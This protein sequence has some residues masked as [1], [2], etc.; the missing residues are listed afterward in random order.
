[1]REQALGEGRV[2]EMIGTALGLGFIAPKQFL[3]CGGIFFLCIPLI[4]RNPPQGLLIF[5]CIYGP[6]WMLTGNDPTKFFE[7][8]HKPKK[9]IAEEPVLEFN[10]AGIP[11]PVKP[12]RE[13]TTYRIKGK[14]RTYHHIERKFHLLTYGQIELEGKEIGFYLLRRGTQLMFIFAWEV[15]GHDPSM[16]GQQAMEIL[17]AC[18]DALTNVPGDIDLKCYQEIVATCEAYLRMQAALLASKEHDTLSRELIKSR[19]RRGKQLCEE[20]RLVENSITVFAKY[21]V[22]LGGEYA[23]SETWLDELLAKTQ[24]LVGALKGKNFESQ[25]AWEKVIDYA[26]RYAYRKVNSQLSSPQGFGMRLRTKTVHELFGADY[27]KLHKPPVPPV[28]QY[29]VYNED[30]LQP[31]VVHDLG[32]HAIGTLFEPQGGISAKPEFDRHYAYLPVKQQYEAFVRLG[33]VRSFPKDKENVA[34]GYLRF[35][36]NILSGTTEAIYNCRVVT[37]LTP[38]RSGF[39]MLQLDRMISNSV[40]REALAAK[41]QTV[42]VVAMRRREQAIEARDLLEDKNLPY[43]CSVGVWLYRDSLDELN[44]ATNELIGRIQAAASVERVMNA[45]EDVWFQSWP[46]EWEAFLTKPHHRRQKYLGFQALPMLP[47]IKVK[48]ADKQ[49]MMLVTRE[50]SSPLYIDI[51]NRKNHT[52]I[53]AQT[54]VGKSFLMMDMI[55]EYVFNNYL[56]VI[57]DFPRP[58]GT[59]TYTVLVPI[60]QKLGVRAVYYNVRE[61]VMNIIELPDLRHFKSQKKRTEVWQQAFGNHVRLLCAIVMGTTTNSDRELL[62]NSLLTQCYAAF[63]ADEAIKRRYESAIQGGFGSDAYQNMPI[64]ETFVQYAEHWFSEYIRNKHETI[65]VLVNDTIDVILTQLRGVL[66][67]SLGASI[68]GISSFDPN[69]NLLVIGL[70]NVSESLDSLIY[71]MS[72]LNVLLRQSFSVLRSLLAIDEGTILYKFPFFARETGIIPVHGRKWGCNF[73][74]AAQELQ[75]ILNSCSGNDIF[76]NLDNILGGHISSSAIPDMLQL[77]FREEL[78][79]RYTS[80]AY[81]P[82]SE[83]LQSYWYLKRGDQ[84]LEATHPASELLLALGAT[85]PDE[86]AARQRTMALHPGD[87]IAGIKHF[88]KLIVQAKRQGLPM[89]SIHPDVMIDENENDEE[90]N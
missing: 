36:W 30:G 16:S 57:F 41:K 48:P 73:L 80:E 38:D 37:E 65:S 28:P 46:F 51:A 33:Q 86:N 19:A 82:S 7:R 8:L 24:P 88:G 68:N 43:W 13:S 56:A 44:K 1:M 70:T 6:F 76:K 35:L 60:L 63:H 66:S 45:T 75:T 74:I 2:N 39:E 64:L 25:A 32:T 18:N 71:A 52:A 4:F 11:M 40:K 9:Y 77:E 83:L 90:E 72:G 29:I 50:L 79:R 55:F 22:P 31:P 81:K 54:G 15:Y 26:Y 14:Q 62:V 87:P 89:D 49:G 23:I 17:S 34:R 47:M 20:G 67:T 59:S 12:Q 84:H 58:D 85:D 21:R 69:V 53:I 5:A 27:L 42:D 10:P 78:I 3:F 61:S